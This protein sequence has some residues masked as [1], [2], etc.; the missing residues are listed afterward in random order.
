MRSRLLLSALAAA[1][2]IALLTVA[3]AVAATGHSQSGVK[4][5]GT[6]RVNLS[7]TDVQFLDPALD[8]EFYGWS[9]LFSTCVRLL[10]YPDAGGVAGTKLIPEGATSFPRISAN[11]RTY[12]F[13][14]R[15]GHRF[16]TG[17]AVTAQSY[18]RA[19]ERML[20]KKMSSPGATFFSDIV[21]A[22]AVLAGKRTRPAGMV[23]KGNTISF[24]LTKANP[25]FLSRVAMPFMCAQPPSLPIDSKG[26]LTPPM[27]GPF[28][29]ASRDVGRTVVLKR[30]PNYGGKRQVSLDEIV[31][32]VNTALD[33]SLLQ[34]RKGEA[35]YDMLGLPPTAH[36]GLASQFG[37]NKGRYW[38]HPALGF[39]YLALN[40]KR[41]PLADVNLRK[42]VNFAVDR[43]ALAKLNGYLGGTPTDQILPPGIPGYR[44]AA[45]YPN[46]PNVARAKQLAGG[47]SGTLRLYYPRGAPADQQ[48]VV[49]QQ[50][51][52]QIG[53]DVKLVPMNF[54][55]LVN[56]T[57]HPSEPYDM[58]AIAWFADYA[59]PFDFIDIL[60]NGSRISPANNVNLAQFDQPAFNRKMDT[61]ARLVGDRRYR[62][63][64]DLD[65][66]IMR[67][68]APLA[69]LYTGNNREFVSARLGCYRY[70]P[71]YQALSLAV[72]CLK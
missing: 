28:Y 48:A 36:R 63:Y 13:T 2:G 38:V 23:V 27:A 66:D 10:S 16:N 53:Y 15:R 33:A 44:N 52:K 32:T 7:T 55:V 39:S 70:V 71:A 18:A 59:D 22:Q 8:Y 68:A 54:D 4:R 20:N 25:D 69:P 6:L 19:V 41:G 67:N 14:I 60:L 51:L 12:T 29:I 9:V 1:G 37:V 46:R 3:A 64:G 50:N 5:G 34:V 61:A 58:V 21:G 24:R 47:K 17:E 30:N 43:T 45:L 72:V 65:V 40:T 31:I 56:A 57:G 11:G 35:D 49:I 26:V 62:A 42:A